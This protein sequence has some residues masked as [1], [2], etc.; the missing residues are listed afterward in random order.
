MEPD[1]NGKQLGFDRTNYL[2]LLMQR[3]KTWLGLDLEADPY[4]GISH[5]SQKNDF[6]IRSFKV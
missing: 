6:W 1:P 3:M 5:K 2:K 4:G